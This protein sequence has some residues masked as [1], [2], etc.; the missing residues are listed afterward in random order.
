MTTGI[1]LAVV[2]VFAIVYA[3]ICTRYRERWCAREGFEDLGKVSDEW[4]QRLKNHERCFGE[5]DI[6]HAGSSLRAVVEGRTLWLLEHEW[7]TGSLNSRRVAWMTFVIWECDSPGLPHFRLSRRSPLI[8]RSI[9]TV[10][11]A[12]LFLPYLLMGSFGPLTARPSTVFAPADENRHFTQEFDRLYQV[13]GDVE[14][15]RQL[16]TRE[17]QI[18]FIQQPLDGD[19]VAIDC[20]LIWQARGL[21]APWNLDE[22]RDVALQLRQLFLR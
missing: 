2:I 8:A 19:L 9:G 10:A 7:R 22:K 14:A 12:I 5:G 17:I 13:T 16:F 15:A 6:G 3:V 1:F 20:M 4:F 11:R 18:Y 21:L